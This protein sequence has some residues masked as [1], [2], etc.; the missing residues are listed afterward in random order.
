MML[1]DVHTIWPDL[2]LRFFI[3]V[4]IGAKSAPGIARLKLHSFSF[5]ELFRSLVIE[6][7]SFLIPGWKSTPMSASP[8]T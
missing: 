6:K 4:R 5:I 7:Q 2:R 1:Y 8:C 3:A